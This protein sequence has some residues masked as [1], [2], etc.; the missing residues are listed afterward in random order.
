MKITEAG[1]T[2]AG[3]TIDE[4]ARRTGMTVRNI[5]AHQSRGLLPPP[6]V[7]G[8]T[9]YYGD[10]HL[11]R[12]ELIRELQTEGL[13]LEAIRRLV[14]DVGDSSAEVLD[15]TRALR[16]PFE[17]EEPEIVEETWLAERWGGEPDP[18]LFG[19][20]E[21]LGLL[22]RM[23]DGKVEVISPRLMKA[24]GQL[25]EL[26]VD[27]EFALELAAKMRRSSEAVAS[28]YVDLFIK[29]VWEPFDKAGR[30]DED[31]PKVREALERLRPLASEALLAMFQIAMTE[32]TEKALGRALK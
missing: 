21:K 24:G 1:M 30:P 5:R 25:A 29:N 12:I 26:G 23:G 2:E 10:E 11:A 15:F 20:A 3:M 4:L 13:N 16:A 19:K 8:R 9:G 28:A 7:R 14:Q 27:V 18:K 31:W 22:R 17:D 6:Q 32:A